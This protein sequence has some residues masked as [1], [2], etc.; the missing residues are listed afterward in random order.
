MIMKDV[1]KALQGKSDLVSGNGTSEELIREAEETL[2]L[3]FASDYRVYLMY[4]GIVA[5][6]SHELTGISSSKRLDVI[7]VTINQRQRNAFDLSEMYVIEEANIDGIVIWQS[8]NGDIYE[9]VMD[10]EPI[11]ICES[12]LEYIE[13]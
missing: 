12:L 2:G 5:F 9:T 8:S 6:D 13:L 11:K 10:S 7:Q 4:Y 3:R 1:I